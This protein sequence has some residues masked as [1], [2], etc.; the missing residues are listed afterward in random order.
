MHEFDIHERFE[1]ILPKGNAEIIFNLSDNISYFNS[2]SESRNFPHCVING[3][4]SSS[5]NLIKKGQQ[6]FIGI[7]LNVF[8]L[9]ILFNIPVNEFNNRVIDGTLICKSLDTLLH[10]IASTSS[11]NEQVDRIL[12]W[13]H[14]KISATKNEA[15][16]NRVY[17]FYYDTEI[18]DMKVN[19][20]CR[21][22]NY[23]ERHF[24]RLSVEWLGMNTEAFILYQKYLN[25]LRLLHRS[26]LSLTQVGLEAGYYD[27]SHF[28]R[29]FKSFTDL[30]PK[31]YR[32]VKSDLPGHIFSMI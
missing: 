21:K 12:K 19:N 6:I 20:V 22:Y 11:F 31:E 24:R 2:N 15:E 16:I 3:V 18:K 25:T 1:K 26:D 4:N 7:Q 13:F 23:S 14:Y 29:E 27:Q 17:K 9:K 28:I 10:Q 32:K 30:T 5:F 8:A